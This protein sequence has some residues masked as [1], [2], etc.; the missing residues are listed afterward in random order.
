MTGAYHSHP[1][2]VARPSARD[3]TEAFPDFIHVLVG[4]VADALEVRAW[5]LVGGNF[6]EIRLVLE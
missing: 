3:R 4:P 5:R 6:V 2:T 1:R